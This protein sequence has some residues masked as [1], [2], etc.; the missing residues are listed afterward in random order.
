MEPEAFPWILKIQSIETGDALLADF[1]LA[2]LVDTIAAITATTTN[3]AGSVRFMAPELLLPK[4]DSSDRHMECKTTSSDVFAFGCL[5]LQVLCYASD[6][7]ALKI[8]AYMQ[9]FTGD[10]PY[11]HLAMEPQVILSIIRGEKPHPR[12]PSREAVRRGFDNDLWALAYKCWEFNPGQ[13]PGMNV[14]SAELEE[15]MYRLQTVG[16]CVMKVPLV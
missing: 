2:R 15:S 14:V 5:M 7:F 9:I 11:N 12:P 16:A 10:R 4:P 3:F 1:G 8:P 6:V 13:R